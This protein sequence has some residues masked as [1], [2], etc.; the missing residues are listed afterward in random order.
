MHPT[1]TAPDRPAPRDVL[2][3]RSTTEDHV[4]MVELDGPVCAFTADH[5]DAE[6]SRLQASGTHRL[7][8]DARNVR[9]LCLDGIDVLV[10]HEERCAARGGGLVLRHL[11]P[12]AQRV[13]DVLQL[14]RLMAPLAAGAR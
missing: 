4:A 1:P 3:V 8:I 13:L 7:V 12:G 2:T 6:L 14:Q 5:L 11:R 10:A 9:P